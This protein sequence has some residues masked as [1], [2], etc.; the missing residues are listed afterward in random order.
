M[1][2]QLTVHLPKQAVALAD[3][4]VEVKTKSITITIITSCLFIY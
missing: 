1:A 3:I 4:E 2:H